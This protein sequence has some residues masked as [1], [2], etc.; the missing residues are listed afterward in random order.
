M[1]RFVVVLAL[2]AMALCPGHAQTAAYVA[3]PRT[4][5]DITAI[6]DQKL[7]PEKVA[8]MR[9]DVDAGPPAGAGRATLA[10]F[11]YD[12]GQARLRLGR[13]R[14]A[15][16]DA[17]KALEVA[18]GQ[19][20]PRQV[21]LLHQFVAIAYGSAGDPSKSLQ[22][23]LQIERDAKRLNLQGAFFNA[24]KGIAKTLIT[25]GDFNQAETYVRKSQA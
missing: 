24:Y 12:Q 20:D 18:Q 2:L 4:S 9:S 7:D 13:V 17:E 8:N 5:A 3:P 11:Y 16:A 21:N 14:E 22:Q 23:Y 6:L 1:A 19:V 15:L 10:T 25:M